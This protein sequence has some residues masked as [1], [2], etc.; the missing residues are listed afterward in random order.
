MALCF[1]QSA[2]FGFEQKK[3]K[4][5][6]NKQNAILVLNRKKTKRHKSIFNEF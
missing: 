4:T 5:T 1:P 3:N 2:I 6:T